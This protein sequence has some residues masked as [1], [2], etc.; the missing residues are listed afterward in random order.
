M[1][2]WGGKVRSKTFFAYRHFRKPNNYI[3]LCLSRM[4][5]HFLLIGYVYYQLLNCHFNALLHILSSVV[6]FLCA[7]NIIF[8]LGDLAKFAARACAQL[9]GNI[10]SVMSCYS[11]TRAAELCNRGM[12]A[13]EWLQ[14]CAVFGHRFSGISWHMPQK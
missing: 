8:L 6:D 3:C 2:I 7:V 12:H 14:P 9:R 11:G 1:K 13:N 5:R 10:D 4:K